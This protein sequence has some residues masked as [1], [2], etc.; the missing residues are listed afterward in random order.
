MSHRVSGRDAD[1]CRR[2]G[3]SA[4]TKS[5]EVGTGVKGVAV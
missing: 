3:I 4:G 1:G 2:A 5:E